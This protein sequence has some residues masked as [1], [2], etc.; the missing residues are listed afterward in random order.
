MKKAIIIYNSQTGITKKYADAIQSF[1]KGKNIETSLMPISDYNQKVKLEAD[2][3]MLGCWTSGL[4]FFGQHPDKEWV[5][6]AKQL[7]QVAIPNIALF[8]T[9]KLA[10][11]SMF[12]NMKKHIDAEPGSIKVELKSRNGKLSDIDIALLEKFLK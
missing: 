5:K 3:L 12:K 4:F 11:G 1:V 6:F 9:Y 8:T 2:Y 10:T 7:P